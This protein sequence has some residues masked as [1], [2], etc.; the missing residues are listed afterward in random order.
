M[1]VMEEIRFAGILRKLM[2]ERGLNQLQLSE[3]LGVRQ[4]QVSN[5]LNGRSL[6]GYNSLRMLSL[7]LDVKLEVFF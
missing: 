5:W 6:P 3:L 4:S 2:K 7:K 1:S